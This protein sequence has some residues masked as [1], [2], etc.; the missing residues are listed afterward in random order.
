[1]TE[2]RKEGGVGRKDERK[3]GRKIMKE[4]GEEK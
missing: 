2:E 1:M 3:E 4:G